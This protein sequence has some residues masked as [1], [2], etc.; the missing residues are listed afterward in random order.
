MFGTTLVATVP[1]FWQLSLVPHPLDL[2]SHIFNTKVLGKRCSI[3]QKQPSYVDWRL[4][5]MHLFF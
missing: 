5:K 2:S 1:R 4:C 3:M